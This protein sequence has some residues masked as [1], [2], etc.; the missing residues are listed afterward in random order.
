[1]KT[2]PFAGRSGPFCSTATKAA[3]KAASGNVPLARQRVPFSA[4]SPSQD[5]PV[6]RAERDLGEPH[7][8]ICP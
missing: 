3:T 1:M 4:R 5:S 7:D 2:L 6:N 8:T